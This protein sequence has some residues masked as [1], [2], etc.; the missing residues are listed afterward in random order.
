MLRPVDGRTSVEVTGGWN[1]PDFERAA[2]V[3]ELAEPARTCVAREAGRGHAVLWGGP[4]PVHDAPVP[5]GSD[6]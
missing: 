3:T 6:A 2:G 5:A 4:A 1:R